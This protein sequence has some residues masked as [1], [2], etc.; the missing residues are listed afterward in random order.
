MAQSLSA[1]ISTLKKVRSVEIEARQAN[2]AVEYFPIDLAESTSIR[3]SAAA[4]LAKHS[5]IDV[6]VNAAGWNDIQSFVENAPDYMDRVIAINL[7]GRCTLR[8][9]CFR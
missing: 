4:V 8:K 9:P 3:T 2:L 1:P 6:L 7:G 5:R